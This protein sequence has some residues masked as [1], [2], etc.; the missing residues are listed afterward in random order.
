[1]TRRGFPLLVVCLLV[2]KRRGGPLPP[3]L[4]LAYSRTTRRGKPF[5]VVF[6]LVFEQRGGRGRSPP[7]CM[8]V[9]FRTARREGPSS[10]YVGLFSND[11]EG[12]ALPRCLS[13]DFRMAR[14]EGEEPSSSCYF[15][16]EE[17]GMQRGGNPSSLHDFLFA[18]ASSSLFSTWRGGIPLLVASFSNERA[19]I[20]GTLV[21]YLFFMLSY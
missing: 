19:S 8:S 16:Y 18:I 9:G 14:G 3:R 1:M 12:E 7:R 6:L 4:T 20:Q 15:H 2:F 10:P 13:V 5:L 17:A 21:F 11:E